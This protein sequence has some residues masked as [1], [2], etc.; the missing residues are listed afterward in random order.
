M[1][2]ARVHCYHSNKE[3]Y[4]AINCLYMYSEGGSGLGDLYTTKWKHYSAK[5]SV[6]W[7]ILYARYYNIFAEVN[8]VNTY[9]TESRTDYR[10]S[11]AYAEE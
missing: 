6:P 7:Y 3:I 1:E 4:W 10:N 2:L 5:S 9:T 11:R 8:I